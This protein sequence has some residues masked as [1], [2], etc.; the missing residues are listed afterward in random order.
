ML[1]LEDVE[2]AI[3]L[4]PMAALIAWRDDCVIEVRLAKGEEWTEGANAVHVWIN[5]EVDLRER[6]NL[7]KRLTSTVR[8][9]SN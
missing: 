5:E 7:F 1:E 9:N 3:R 6:V 8:V 2:R 4:V